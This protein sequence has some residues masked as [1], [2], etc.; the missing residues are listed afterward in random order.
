MKNKC[1]DF[2]VKLR[3]V[4]ILLLLIF[5]GQT[6]ICQ[7]KSDYPLPGELTKTDSVYLKAIANWEKPG[8]IIDSIDGIPPGK[9]KLLA[10]KC[11]FT[12]LNNRQGPAG[13]LKHDGIYPS[14]TGFRGFWAWDSW[15]HAYALAI[16]APDLAKNS[17]RAMFDYQ[18]TC[19]M[20]AD[21]IFIDSTQNNWRDTKPP[22]SAWAV[23]EVAKSTRDTEFA[24]EM[25]PKVLKYHRWWYTH[26]DHDQNG[27][28]EYGSTD[29][30]LQAA[31][32]ESGWD[33]A[34]RF[35]SATMVQ[36]N[37]HAWSMTQESVDLNC[38]LFMEKKCLVVLARISGNDSLASDI[39]LEGS[40]LARQIRTMM[41]D[42]QD[43]YFFDIGLFT[44]KPV[45]VMEPNGWI[46]LWAEIVT[47]EQAE[48]I[49]DHI[50]N[51]EEFNTFVPFPTVAANNPQ[52]NPEEGYWRGPVWLDQAYFAIY[53]LRRYKFNKEADL[54]LG[55]LLRNC[56][57]LLDP[58]KSIREN[59]HPLTGKGLNAEN[60]SW[61]AAHLLMM[62]R[63]TRLK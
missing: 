43:G 40:A 11:I 63:E 30:T 32:W 53:G 17:I 26:R 62:I 14:Y 8:R 44:K 57:G 31:R 20:V 38:Y 19:G 18:D 56:E 59:Y 58:A 25:F 23:L 45:K 21:C 48:K 60:F 41:W 12:L 37:S 16:I 9:I 52:F 5:I 28:C 39:Q 34:V 51:P 24:R 2:F 22:L 7:E 49:R 4:L 10:G 50:M 1:P 15:K 29:G 54:L 27:L 46:P 61:S 35:D 36:N 47:K 13:G 6:T 3:T 55:K 33:N 42:E